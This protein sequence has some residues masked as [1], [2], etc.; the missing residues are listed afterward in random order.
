MQRATLLIDDLGAELDR[1]LV[2]EG[3]ET[4]RL[5]LLRATTA[6]ITRAAND[7]IQAYQRGRR[8]VD[9]DLKRTNASREA[10]LAMRASLQA[11][12]VDLLRSLQAAG[13]RYPWVDDAEPAVRQAR[14]TGRERA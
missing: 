3:A 10:T 2:G 8:A 7:A 13:R 6:R 14:L 5:R 11:A 1:R 9:A 12:R 4:E